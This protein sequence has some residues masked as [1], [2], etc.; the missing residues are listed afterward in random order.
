M[1]LIRPTFL[2]KRLAREDGF[3]ML[4]T[5]LSLM[6]GTLLV[7]AA[8]TSAN[9]D[10]K[11]TQRSTLQAKAYY[12]AVAG[13]NR[14]QYQLSSSPEYWSKCP[15]IANGSGGAVTVPGT[16]DEAYTVK[17]L[18][19]SSWKTST[20]CESGKQA[21]ILETKGTANG[22][23]RVLSTGTATEGP[24]TVTR[25]IVAT[26]SHP[27]FTKY[28]YESNFEVEDPVNF[29]KAASVCEYYYEE[30][31][32]KGLTT[33]CPVIQFAPTD[34]VNG[35]MHTNDA[36][37]TCTKSGSSPKFGREGHN[38]EIAM[39]GGHYA[40]SGCTN[41]PNIVGTYT[42]SAGSILPPPT[43]QEILE[44]AETHFEG[45]TEI[46]LKP[47]APN[48]MKVTKPGQAAT[49]QNFPS[50][51]VLY[52]ENSKSEACAITA[53]TPF[54][55]DTENDTGCG[56]VYVHGEYTESLTIASADDVIV[57]GNLETTHEANGE[58][59][60]GATLGLIAENFVRLYHP[61][62][63][64]YTTPHVEPPSEP[65]IKGRCLT[66]KQAEGKVLRSTEVT[67]IT[68][69]GLETGAEVEGTVVGMIE[70]GTTVSELKAS[71]KK[72][73]LSKAAKPGVD[74]EI[75]VKL[76]NG[77]TEVANVSTTGLEVGQEVEGAGIEA[78]TKISEIK[79]SEKKLKLSK[80]AKP[81]P[82]ELSNVKLLRSTE[83]TNIVTTGLEVGE[84]VEGTGIEAGTT[85]S[86]IKASEKK[87][88]L[89]KAAK[90]TTTSL[91][92]KTLRSIEVS[93]IT[94]TGLEVGDEVEGTGIEAGTTISEIKASEKK[95]KLSKAAKPT[96]T[97]LSAKI[98]NGSTEITNITTTGLEV[99]EEVEGSGT[100]FAAGTVITEIKTGSK[101]KVSKAAK[102]TETTTLKFYGENPA[103]KFYGSSV[104]LKFWGPSTLKFYG[105]NT[106]L[107]FLVA[108]NYVLNSSLNLC[109]KSESG[110]DEYRPTENVYIKSCEEGSYKGNL[111]CEYEN[112][113]GGCAEK[114]ENLSAAEDSTNHWGALKDPVIDAAILSTKHSWIVNNYKC[115]NQLGKLTVWGSIAQF[116]RGPV[117]QAG[118][119]GYIKNYNYDDRLANQQPPSFLSP[120]NASSWKV[121]RETAPPTS[122]TG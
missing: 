31:V 37:A 36:A 17:T 45:R 122:F 25:K 35:P 89:S 116:W 7:A 114:A 121:S 9:G 66:T 6:V 20:T 32:K 13:V 74:A 43:D 48:T 87:I 46:E 47:G 26:F 33:T 34:E 24:N 30:R 82:T 102:N 53:Y 100:Q 97:S 90:P 81:T 39:N 113:S 101:I 56:N 80:A 14:Y 63:K 110:W 60:G 85:I 76:V 29:G 68:T 107:K 77:S 70:S 86:E 64:G 104:T 94:T 78:G 55:A 12:A 50:N 98:T 112:D 67:G 120:T 73:K 62:K 28:V 38:D 18:R 4:F 103:L 49:I 1:R 15:T 52:V 79:A 59:T 119:S 22:T 72:L 27:G 2:A 69:T 10:I 109:H 19:S 5:L 111:F 95:I 75:S 99:G 83:I 84:E 42:E 96:A 44:A 115:G 57:N 3:T 91:T 16:T 8:F 61:V 92:G 41:S 58:P 106:M 93:N 108:S 23:F 54:N 21:S 117:G 105:E 51:G 118:G 65:A 40:P 71:E 11:L 88:K